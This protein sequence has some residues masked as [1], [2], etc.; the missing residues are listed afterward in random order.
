MVM[1]RICPSYDSA[2]HEAI[3]VFEVAVGDDGVAYER[4][5]VLPLLEAR[6]WGLKQRL[7]AERW[8]REV[9]GITAGGHA[10]DTSRE[11]RTILDQAARA[12][13]A[14]VW[15]WGDGSFSA[16]TP[17]DLGGVIAAVTS[18]VAA[19]FA[20]EAAQAAA[21]DA[22]DDLEV[23]AAWDVTDPAAWPG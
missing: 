4:Q 10:V 21:I 20:A 22:C 6:R 8:R 2:T 18:H 7:A 13:Y 11:A 15:K 17:E 9:G 19:C 12:G 1:T 14:G 5:I 16:V 3:D 23:L